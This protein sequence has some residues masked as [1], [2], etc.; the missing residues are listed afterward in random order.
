MAKEVL[1]MLN[2]CKFWSTTDP[3][4]GVV[5]KMQEGGVPQKY[6]SSSAQKICSWCTKSD[7]IHQ[8]LQS[9]SKQL[10][11]VGQLVLLYLHSAL[12][13][14]LLPYID[15][16]CLLSVLDAHQC[17]VKL[18][19]PLGV[20]VE[21]FVVGLIQPQQLTWKLRRILCRLITILLS[22]C[23][24]PVR[25]LGCGRGRCA[26]LWQLFSDYKGQ[27]T[28]LLKAHLLLLNSR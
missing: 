27:R 2:A 11:L 5:Q 21:L 1:K 22:F 7:A 17:S 6:G 15:M 20:G 25:K 13:Y 26:V 4:P 24:Y 16:T 18:T 10:W 12:T 3:W 23:Y 14:D 9:S 19:H 28:L 8:N